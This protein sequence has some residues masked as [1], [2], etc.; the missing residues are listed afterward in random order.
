[1]M[2]KVW[3][4]LITAL[5]AFAVVMVSNRIGFLRRLAMGGHV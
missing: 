5:I 2:N 4:I 3:P 1:M